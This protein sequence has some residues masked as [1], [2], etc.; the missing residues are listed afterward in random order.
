MAVTP[1]HKAPNVNNGTRQALPDA[2]CALST[3]DV[4]YV[5]VSNR[6]GQY[7]DYVA[8]AERLSKQPNPSAYTRCGVF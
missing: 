5:A 4:K 1:G 3:A 6:I 2:A 8:A 7:A